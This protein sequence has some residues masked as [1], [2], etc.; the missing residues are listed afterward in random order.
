LTQ[1]DQSGVVPSDNSLWNF[2]G[3]QVARK[4]EFI[5][6][7]AFALS[8]TT[9]AWQIVNS[10]LGAVVKLFP[11]DQV[12]ITAVDKLGRNYPGQP[13]LLALIARMA[14]VNQGDTGH[15][16]V[17]QREYVHFLLGNR[18]IEQRWYEFGSSDVQDG[19]LTFL[20]DSDARPFPLNAGSASSHET[21]FAAWEVD[22]EGK[23]SAK[24]DPSANFVTWED[25]LK[26]IK[27]TRQI[28]LDTTADI[29]PDQ[30]V[31]AGCLVQL[32]DWEIAV[33]ETDQWLSA[34]C[35]PKNDVSPQRKPRLPLLGSAP[36]RQSH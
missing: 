21:L 3:L 1:V 20:R 25:F 33:L 7:A 31:S 10:T 15:N 29:F 35:I 34:A 22:C 19:K 26:I 11:T 12:V 14:Y 24:C 5:A 30:R 18:Q 23:P 17:V 8:I 36:V 13:D 16:A 2:F 4:T 9:L 6:L 27:S 28:S 32:R